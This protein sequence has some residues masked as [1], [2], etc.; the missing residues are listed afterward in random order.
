MKINE[1]NDVIGL[2]NRIVYTFRLGRLEGRDLDKYLKA[3]LET[4]L[5]VYI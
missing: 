2:G 3:V 4:E 1:R 5:W